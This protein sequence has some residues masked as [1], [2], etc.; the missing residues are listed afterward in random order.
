[1]RFTTLLLKFSSM[2]MEIHA[3]NLHF[4]LPV[5]YEILAHTTSSPLATAGMRSDRCL[6]GH[7]VD[8][9]CGPTF[10]FS[11]AIRHNLNSD[12]LS[13]ERLLDV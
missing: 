2:E 12:Y 13:Y 1:M 6:K 9:S 5:L 10:C 8:P 3:C 4:S 11:Y 7:A